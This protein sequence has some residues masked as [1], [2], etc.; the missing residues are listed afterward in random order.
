ELLKE[1]KK[2]NTTL[3]V[4]MMTAYADNSLIEEALKENAVICLRKPFKIPKLLELLKKLIK[5]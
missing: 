1:V 3:S 4:I 5:K 2:F